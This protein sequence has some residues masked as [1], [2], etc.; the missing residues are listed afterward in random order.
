QPGVQNQPFIVW[1]GLV[2]V[3]VNLTNVAWNGSG[4]GNQNVSV[5]MSNSGGTNGFVGNPVSGLNWSTNF[6]QVVLTFTV[7]AGAASGR[8]EIDAVSNPEP[9]TLALFA[10]GAAALGGFAWK[11]RRSRAARP[12]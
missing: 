6:T 5:G 2:T 8:F 10:T 3:A 9:G 7:G 4:A 1:T 11:R 12:S